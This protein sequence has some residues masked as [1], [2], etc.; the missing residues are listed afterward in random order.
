VGTDGDSGGLRG[1][2]PLG[3]A[4]GC[5]FKDLTSFIAARLA[6]ARPEAYPT[7]RARRPHGW[8]THW[9]DGLGDAPQAAGQLALLEGVDLGEVP[10]AGEDVDKVAGEEV[11]GEAAVLVDAVAVGDARAIW[12]SPVWRTVQ[13]RVP[14]GRRTRRV[15][16]A[17]AW[18]SLVD[19]A[20]HSSMCAKT[21]ST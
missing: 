21:A 12:P 16:P 14:P 1:A 13:T 4:D 7:G 8:P 18:I 20:M 3:G 17:A 10:A 6:T 11:D 9:G 19:R 15:S 5:T 2:Q